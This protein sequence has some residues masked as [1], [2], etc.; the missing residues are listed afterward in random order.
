MSGVKAADTASEVDHPIAVD[1]FDDRA[2]SLATKTG[3]A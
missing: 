3:V 2:I 1:I